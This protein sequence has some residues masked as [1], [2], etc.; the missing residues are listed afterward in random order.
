M[1]TVPY[2][3]FILLLCA[4]AA[5]AAGVM[6]VEYGWVYADYKYSSP[7]HRDSAV[8][9]GK[10]IP[11]NCVILD[12]DV[13][14]G[15][16]R[17]LCVVLSNRKKNRLNPRFGNNSQNNNNYIMYK[18]KKNEKFLKNSLVIILFFFFY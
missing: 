8:K 15:K 10:F 2:E 3:M 11:E 17:C 5:A 4:A 12:V 9:S 13:Y 14:Q 18:K 7:Q 6:D 1:P 16:Y